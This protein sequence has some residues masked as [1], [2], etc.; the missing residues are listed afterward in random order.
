MDWSIHEATALNTQTQSNVMV[1]YSFEHPVNL[2]VY[3][4]PSITEIKLLVLLVRR[5]LEDC[6]IEEPSGQRQVKMAKEESPSHSIE[7]ELRSQECVGSAIVVTQL[8]E[9][10]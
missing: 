6:R 9:I 3:V 4:A 1:C 7:V 5:H 2:M 8:P 10:S